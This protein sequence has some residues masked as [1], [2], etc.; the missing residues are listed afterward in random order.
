MTNTFREQLQRATLETFDQTDEETWLS[1]LSFI[2]KQTP[3][4]SRKRL[5]LR[6]EQEVGASSKEKFPAGSNAIPE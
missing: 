4:T 6:N 2:L 5:G 1:P 3:L